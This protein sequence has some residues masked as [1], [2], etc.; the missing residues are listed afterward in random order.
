MGRLLKK[1]DSQKGEFSTKMGDE[2]NGSGV[3]NGV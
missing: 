2:M 3:Y 1:M